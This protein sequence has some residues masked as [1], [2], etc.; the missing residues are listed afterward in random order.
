MKIT[1]AGLGYVGLSNAVLLAHKNKVTAFDIDPM[2]VDKVANKISPIND[3]EIQSF[4]E[5]ERLNLFATVDPEIAFAD[6]D[7]VV[8]ATP[9]NYNPNLNYFDVTSVEACIRQALDGS[10]HAKIV[11]R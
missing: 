4:L 9:T 10:S 3:A 1:V 6:A 5:N 11:V 8:V 2:R 7:L